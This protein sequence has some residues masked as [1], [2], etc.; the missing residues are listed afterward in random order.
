MT[1]VF[2]VEAGLTTVINVSNPKNVFRPVLSLDRVSFFMRK[3][4]EEWRRTLLL[5]LEQ[6]K[7]FL[8]LVEGGNTK[9]WMQTALKDKQRRRARRTPVVTL[10]YPISTRLGRKWDI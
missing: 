2:G 1:G 3:W 4:D 6:P 8:N 10:I 7:V 5:N 9:S